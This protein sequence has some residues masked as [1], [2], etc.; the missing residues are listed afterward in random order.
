MGRALKPSSHRILIKVVNNFTWNTCLKFG[1]VDRNSKRRWTLKTP[2]RETLPSFWILG[3]K[4]HRAMI[5]FATQITTTLY[6]SHTSKT[7]LTL[8]ASLTTC[9]LQITQSSLHSMFAHSKPISHKKKGSNCL[10]ILQRT[11]TNPIPQ[12]PHPL[13]GTLWS[14]VKRKFVQF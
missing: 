12:F 10:P 14:W 1:F 3:E 7:Q 6:K 8:F 5:N 9:H 4:S 2:I 13:L 11:L